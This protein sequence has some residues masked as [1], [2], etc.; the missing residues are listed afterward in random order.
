M[1]NAFLKLLN[2]SITASWLVLAV[3]LLRLLLKKAPKAIMVVMWALVGIRLI[4]PFSFES[5]LSLIPSSETV[6]SDILYTATP[7]IYSGIPTLNSAVNPIIAGSLS[8]D[9]GDSIN[10]M[11][12]VVF[13][14]TVIWIAGIAAMLLYTVIS[15]LRIHRNVRE[16]APLK[17]GVWLC[18]R[19]DTPFILGIIRPRIYLPSN[20]NIGD[21][22]YVIAHEKSHLKRFDHLWKPLGFLLLTVY[23]FNPILWLAY[24]LLCRDIES[25]CDEKVLADMGSEIKKSYSDALINCSVP[26]KMITACPLAFG[27]IGVKSRIKS[28][29]NYRK[30]AFWISAVAIITCLVTAV[31]FLTNPDK[32]KLK[33]IE[34]LSL[35]SVFENTEAITVSDGTAYRAVMDV[36]NELLLKLGDIEISASAISENRSD[37]DR[38]KTNTLILRTGQDSDRS[39]VSSD[40]EVTY[41]YFSADFSQVW[42]D[43][44]VKPTLSYKVIYPSKA[45]EIFESMYSYSY[46]PIPE[47][48]SEFY[49]YTCISEND[50]AY[51]TLSYETKRFSLSLSL[52][53][54]YAP[55]G[56]FEEDSEY[57]TLYTDD[58]KNKYTFKKDGDNLIFIADMSSD[59]PKYKYSENAAEAIPCISDRAVFEFSESFTSYIS[60]I[61]T[62]IDNDG[63]IEDCV[64]G[65]G[66]TYGIFTFTFS[67]Y[68]KG[69]LEYFNIFN[70]QYGTI[71]FE[72]G[73]DGKV[74]LRGENTGANP[75]IRYFD[76]SI[77][78]GN[79]EL[80]A[81]GETVAYWGEQGTDSHWAAK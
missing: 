21:M 76:I 11:Q 14:A 56:T 66:P 2:M 59:V 80:S 26:R 4:C 73:D 44:G 63:E 34:K 58:G 31:C 77:K 42:A 10:P 36:N 41:I 39:P 71:V 23:W 19:V 64:I 81:D 16:A 32:T 68:E 74:R 78:D 40:T 65:Y 9:T 27:E 48:F 22:K 38:D 54:S 18:D 52:L 47:S 20:I 15:Y 17:D 13:T 12:V 3:I 43:N 1:E 51:I 29:L 37:E 79:I 55:D 33:N 25:A 7:T 67:V 45:K 72:K 46:S 6:P 75:V 69:N 49:S 70:S 62:D 50:S 60:K 57:I 24:I 8:P 30:P 53:S 5:V 35:E 61:S 28:V